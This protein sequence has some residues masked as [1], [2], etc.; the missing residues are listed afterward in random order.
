MHS[1]ERDSEGSALVSRMDVKEGISKPGEE[2]AAILSKY[3][4]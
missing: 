4:R 1:R 2:S 3:S